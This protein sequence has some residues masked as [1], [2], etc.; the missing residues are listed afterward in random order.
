MI[1][2]LTYVVTLALINLVEGSSNSCRIEVLSNDDS[3]AGRY[4]EYFNFKRE[5]VQGL[6][7]DGKLTFFALNSR[8]G[9]LGQVV[10]YGWA[11]GGSVGDAHGRFDFNPIYPEPG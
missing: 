2:V 8:S 10:V 7:K 5:F 1:F 4:G 6:R 3:V 11:S 9:L